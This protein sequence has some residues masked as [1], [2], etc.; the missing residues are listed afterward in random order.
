MTDGAQAKKTPGPHDLMLRPD[1]F[2]FSKPLEDRSLRVFLRISEDLPDWHEQ[3]VTMLKF[4][5]T[6]KKPTGCVGDKAIDRFIDRFLASCWQNLRKQRNAL[7]EG[8]RQ[9]N[10]GKTS[11]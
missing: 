8:K 9:G 7:K 5:L 10:R 1:R 11:S 6:E 3:F 4:F 2:T